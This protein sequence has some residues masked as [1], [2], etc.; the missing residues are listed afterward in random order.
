MMLTLPHLRVLSICDSVTMLELCRFR[1][2]TTVDIGLQMGFDELENALSCLGHAGPPLRLYH[3]G[4][5]LD[6]D[7]PTTVL[8]RAI[9][10]TLPELRTLKLGQCRVNAT[11]KILKFR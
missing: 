3:F 9:S 7:L 8:L 1:M 10:H 6:K 5:R 11:V 2:L 4:V